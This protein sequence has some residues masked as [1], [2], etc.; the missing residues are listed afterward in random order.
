MKYSRQG[1]KQAKAIRYHPRKGV[2]DKLNSSYIIGRLIVTKS[3]MVANLR[4]V[5]LPYFTA[6]V[7]IFA[8]VSAS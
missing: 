2:N 1:T 6:N 5:F 3:E 8:I 4:A 7:L